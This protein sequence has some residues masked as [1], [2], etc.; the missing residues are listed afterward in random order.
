MT[1]DDDCC[2]LTG[3]VDD[4][5]SRLLSVRLW[6][7]TMMIVDFWY[8]R[9]WRWRQQFLM[10]GDCSRMMINTILVDECWLR[11]VAVIVDCCV[12]VDNDDHWQWLYFWLF[13][14]LSYSMLCSNTWR[15][16][17][18]IELNFALNQSLPTD[19]F[20]WVWLHSFRIHCCRLVFFL[21]KDVTWNMRILLDNC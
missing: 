4:E 21:K 9:W 3:D 10:T 11:L 8:R 14:L 1:D 17:K 12:M 5:D 16:Q 15:H 13:Y 6:L 18:F 2:M 7:K 19:H 20:L